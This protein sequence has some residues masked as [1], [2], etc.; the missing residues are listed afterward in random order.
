MFLQ[1]VGHHFSS[2]RYHIQKTGIPDFTAVE[3][4]QLVHVII[5]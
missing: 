1:N 2:N 3:A 5:T 4:T